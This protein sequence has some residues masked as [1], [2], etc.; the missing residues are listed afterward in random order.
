[1]V[2]DIRLLRKIITENRGCTARPQLTARARIDHLAKFETVDDP[3]VSTFPLEHFRPLKSE[4]C[5]AQDQHPRPRALAQQTSGGR[6]YCCG[7]ANPYLPA[8]HYDTPARRI[9]NGI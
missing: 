3:G 2:S 1:A 6:S 5:R 4:S 8:K 7:L 9:Q